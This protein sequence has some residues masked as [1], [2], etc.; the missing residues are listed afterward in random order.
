MEDTITIKKE[1]LWKYSTFVLAA[2]LIIMVF[3]FL[4]RPDATGSTITGSAVNNQQAQQL[5]AQTGKAE[6]SIG[7]APVIGNKNAKVTVIEFTDFSCPYC[8]AASGDNEQYVAYMKQRSSSWEPIVTNL[9]K[10]YVET[11]KARFA[12]KYSMGHSGG[13]PAQL[14]AWCLNDQNS[15]LYWK[16][17][18]KAFAQLTDVEDLAKMKEIAKG[19]GADMA[20]LQTCLDSKKYDSRFDKEQAEGRAAGV[21]GTPAFFVNGQ[22]LSGAQPYS[23]VKQLIDK[24]LA[25]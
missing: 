22:L 15:D 3:V 13:K 5:P 14:V 6:V 8:A 2:L 19:I 16:F 21:Q 10:D 1:N 18:P 23:V 9:I 12:V 20:K 25:K 24:E 4:N 7:D 17:Y 11:G